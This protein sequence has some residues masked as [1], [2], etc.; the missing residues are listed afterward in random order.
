MDGNEGTRAWRRVNEML[1]LKAC[2]HCGGDLVAEHD[3]ACGYLECVQCGH[4]LSHAQ[5]R[6]LGVRVSRQGTLGHLQ[7]P[8][9]PE[10]SRSA[11]LE[12]TP[13]QPYPV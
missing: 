2:P 5:E 7:R 9:S 12:A 1:F 4:V 8:H 3:R 10:P 13:R 6:T 11:A